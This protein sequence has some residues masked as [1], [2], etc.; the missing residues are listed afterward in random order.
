[1]NENQNPWQ[2]IDEQE[3][4][5]NNWI[6]VIHYN[7]INPSGSKGIYGKIHMKNCAMGIV[8]L[9]KDLN[10]YLVGQ[11]RFVLNEYSWEIP[12]GGAPLNDEPLTS[13]RRELLEET[14]LKAARWDKIQEMTLSNSVTDE[15]CIIFLARDLSQHNPLPVK[16]M[17]KELNLLNRIGIK[18]CNRQQ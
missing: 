2:V 14:G 12:E 10:T 18:H 9:D 16:G 1:M 5:N 7:V 17:K 3:M 13:A 6:K 8:P 11:Y 4:Y 15:R